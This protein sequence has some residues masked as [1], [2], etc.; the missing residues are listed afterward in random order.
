MSNNTGKPPGIEPPVVQLPGTQRAAPPDLS[1]MLSNFK[2]N[3]P[4][5]IEYMELDAKYKGAQFKALLRNGFTREEALRML[6]E[7]KS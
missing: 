2:G 7:A 4:A 3:L 5:L 6:L 1:K